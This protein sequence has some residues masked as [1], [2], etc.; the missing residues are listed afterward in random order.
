MQAYQYQMEKNR[1]QAP[2]SCPDKYQKND[3][4][5]SD[6][7]RKQNRTLIVKQRAGDWPH[8]LI[9]LFSSTIYIRAPPPAQQILYYNQQNSGSNFRL[10]LKVENLLC[11]TPQDEKLQDVCSFLMIPELQLPSMYDDVCGHESQQCMFS[12]PC[13][14]QQMWFTLAW[15]SIEV[16]SITVDL[17]FDFCHQ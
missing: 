5:I 11:F 2:L 8:I 10:I 12:S 4:K 16:D 6:K 9:V 17:W 15:F 14:V 7:N 1:Q 3:F 13:P